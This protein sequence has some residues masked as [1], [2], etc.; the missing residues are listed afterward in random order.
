MVLGS[1]LCRYHGPVRALGDILVEV[2]GSQWA[3]TDFDVDVAV[4]S[5]EKVGIVGYNPAVVDG[6]P[7]LL[8]SLSSVLW[9]SSSVGWVTGCFIHQCLC[10][11]RLREV[12]GADTILHADTARI[13]GPTGS[14]DHVGEDNIP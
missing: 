8:R 7:I 5:E 11:E 4:V 6:L 14:V 13:L 9:G 12:F 3:D 1:H 2:L 10:S